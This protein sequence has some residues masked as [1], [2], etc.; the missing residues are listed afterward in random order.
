LVEHEG[1]GKR[2]WRRAGGRDE[3]D[4]RQLR[5]MVGREPDPAFAAQVAE[6]CRRLLAK[7]GDEQLRL[8]V[9]RKMEGYTNEE[10]AAQLGC[11][12][13]PVEGGLRRVG[14]RGENALGHAG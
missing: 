6:E 4:G 3:G 9:L 1:R 14:K 12:P 2:D 8:L 10:G 11:A 7:L 13:S 5:E